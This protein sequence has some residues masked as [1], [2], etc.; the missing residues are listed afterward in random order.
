MLWRVRFGAIRG[1]FLTEIF[2][3]FS[4][5]QNFAIEIARDRAEIRCAPRAAAWPRPSEVPKHCAER[6]HAVARAIRCDSQRIS[7]RHFRKFSRPRHFAIEIVRDLA[8]MRYASVLQQFTLRSGL[9]TAQYTMRR[10]RFGAI[11]GEFLIEFFEIF[12]RPRNF[13]FEIAPKAAVP[14]VLQ[15]GHDP[16]R[17]P[18]TVLSVGM[19]RRVRFGAIRGEFRTEICENFSRPHNFA[20]EIA[21]DRAEIHAAEC[22]AACTTLRGPQQLF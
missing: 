22:F 18:N 16:Q 14:H 19:L 3:I 13:G 6:Q 8:K 4:R 1:E 15:P 7:D 11:L 9:L 10:V 2:E 21:S 12:P 17:S 5:P 20:F